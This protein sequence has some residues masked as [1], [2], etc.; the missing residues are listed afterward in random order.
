MVGFNQSDLSVIVLFLADKGAAADDAE[1][2]QERSVLYAVTSP[3][4]S[5]LRVSHCVCLLLG[6]AL[7]DVSA[8]AYV[9]F[10]VISC[11]T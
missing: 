5:A 3:P 4:H 2:G 1:G 9:V 8:R 11:V 6:H 7:V 10:H